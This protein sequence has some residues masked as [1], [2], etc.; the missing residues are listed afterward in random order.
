[1]CPSSSISSPIKI[2]ARWTLHRHHLELASLPVPRSRIQ[3]ASGHR[4]HPGRAWFCSPAPHR[5]RQHS[6]R[7]FHPG[8]VKSSSQTWA[9]HQ[10]RL[11]AT[12]HRLGSPALL[13]EARHSRRRLLSQ[14]LGR[15]LEGCSMPIR[16]LLFQHLLLLRL[17]THPL[18]RL[19]R[20]RLLPTAHRSGAHRRRKVWDLRH[21]AVEAMTCGDLLRS[22]I[23]DNLAATIVDS[24]RVRLTPALWRIWPA[25]WRMW[26]L[27]GLKA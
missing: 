17:R 12:S 16:C 24:R 11:V 10:H 1:M 27:L 21:Q 9:P 3:T 4:S 5:S 8:K 15:R 25:L 6:R 13:S 22:K 7:Q 18:L 14:H 2:R 23:S 19:L 26:R 20:V